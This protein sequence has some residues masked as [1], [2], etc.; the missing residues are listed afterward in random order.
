MDPRICEVTGAPPATKEDLKK[1]VYKQLEEHGPVTPDK[2]KK[3]DE[4]IDT[5]FDKIELTTEKAKDLEKP[6]E[7]ATP[8]MPPGTVEITNDTPTPAPQTQEK[9]KK[10]KKKKK[11]KWPKPIQDWVDKK[12]AADDAYRERERKRYLY[13]FE[14][15]KFFDKSKRHGELEEKIA[16]IQGT[17]TSPLNKNSAAE[18]D[19]LIQ[20]RDDLKKELAKLEGELEKDFQKTDEGKKAL[21]AQGDA[22]KAADD[23]R[24]AEQEAGKY[25]DQET[26]DDV[27][28]KEDLA[29]AVPA[30]W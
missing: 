24:K 19:K 10:E 3:V 23:T 8:A 5:I 26:K 13:T 20:E 17:L 30:V 27:Q 1:V 11:L 15:K 21:A 7:E 18:N 2:R 16:K 9:Q 28:K 12:K 6:E 29:K 4:G 25:I 14:R 22:E